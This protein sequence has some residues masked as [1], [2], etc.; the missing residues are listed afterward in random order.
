MEHDLQLKQINRAQK[1]RGDLRDYY[2]VCPGRFK[3][4]TVIV[5]KGVG[6]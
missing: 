4:Q 6:P 3:R 1:K 2:Q 5:D